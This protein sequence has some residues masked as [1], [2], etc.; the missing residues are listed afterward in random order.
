VAALSADLAVMA[1]RT[2]LGTLAYLLET[3]RLEAENTCRHGMP[4]S[5]G[6]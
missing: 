5:G 6:R 3:V 1:R 2:G 4:K